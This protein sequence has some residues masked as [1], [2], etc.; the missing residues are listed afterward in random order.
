MVF[1]GDIQVYVAINSSNN[2]YTG[3]WDAASPS[4]YHSGLDG[5]VGAAFDVA[6]R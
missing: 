5:V 6:L 1:P 2:T 3:G 4:G